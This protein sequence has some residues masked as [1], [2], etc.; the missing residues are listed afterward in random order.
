MQTHADANVGRTGLWKFD[1]RLLDLPWGRGRLEKIELEIGLAFYRAEFEV[2]ETCVMQADHDTENQPLVG[3]FMHLVGR[4]FLLTP[5]G[6][7]H[8]VGQGKALLL[9][10]ARNGTRFLLPGGQ[11]VRHVGVAIHPDRLA[12]WYGGGL[13]GSLA[14]FGEAPASGACVRL[15]S[16]SNRL[17]RLK[18]LVFTSLRDGPAARIALGGICAQIMAEALDACHAQE[19]ASSLQ[20]TPR[21]RFAVEDVIAGIR[22]GAQRPLS[23]EEAAAAAGLTRNRL[24]HVFAAIAGQSFAAFQRTERLNL[25]RRLIEDQ[26]FNIGHAAEEAGYNHVTNFS[27]AY[28]R[29]FGETPG[30]TQRRAA[31]S[32]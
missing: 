14:C 9:R 12:Q 7:T 32:R 5:D 10:V 29:Q 19:A 6:A 23:A 3:S 27:V 16:I 21:E 8:E 11:V 4:S 20:M 26:G 25:S 13:P 24:L 17:R 18:S 1:G 15:F 2:E 31:R 22:A 28:R 30:D